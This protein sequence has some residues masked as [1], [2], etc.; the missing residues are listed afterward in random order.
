ML[1]K[2]KTAAAYLHASLSPFP[3]LKEGIF[4]AGIL[5]ALPVL[6]LR[7]VRAALDFRENLPKPTR[8]TGLPFMS[9]FVMA[10]VMAL[11]ALSA[12]ALG[13]SAS[14]AI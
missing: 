7:P 5:M 12:V 13:M 1:K 8:E 14:K 10:S 2:C 9:D 4:V 6:G 3:A 11:R